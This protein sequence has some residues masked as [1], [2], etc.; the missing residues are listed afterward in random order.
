MFKK[1]EIITLLKDYQPEKVEQYATYCF[2]LSLEKNKDGTLKNDW[3][4]K[5]TAEQLAT[6]FKRVAVDKGL[7]LDGVNITLSSRGIQYDYKA[8]KNK[9][10]LIY[11]ETTI[12]NQLVF[13]DDKFT[14]KKENGI[15]IY[16]HILA[17]PFEQ[18]D[19]DIIGGYCVI[20][21][22]RGEFLTTL[23]K[24]DIEKHRKV[25][26]TDKI[27]HDW[28]KEMSLKTVIKKACALH[29]NDVFTNIEQN[30]NENYD[31]ENPLSIEISDKAEIDKAKTVKDLEK[32]YLKNKE[33]FTK[34]PELLKY[35]QTKKAE[36]KN[37]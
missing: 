4:T 12:D 9:L 37:E 10:M 1:D 26:K 28:I 33:K 19:E 32:F 23:S 25:A 8:Y 27:W 16:E 5:K 15:V 36:L 31:L 17:N 3:I 20:K 24:S 14:F 7:F 30:D 21:N 18:K 2:R 35:I 6:Y 34:N 11:P 13:K 29:F 22:K